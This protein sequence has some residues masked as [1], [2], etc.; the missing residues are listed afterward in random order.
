MK[1]LKGCGVTTVSRLRFLTTGNQQLT[2]A[3]HSVRSINSS[4]GAIATSTSPR[5]VVV[6]T[7]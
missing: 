2:T 7:T 5:T 4:V 6:K 3:P 1:K